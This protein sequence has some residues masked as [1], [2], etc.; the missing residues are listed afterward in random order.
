MLLPGFIFIHML[1]RPKTSYH[2]YLLVAFYLNCLPADLLQ[3]IPRST[4]HDWNHKDQIALYGYDWYNENRQLFDTLREVTASKQ[5]LRI[6]RALLRIIALKRFIVRYHDRIKGNI[7]HINEVV[8]NTIHKIIGT[9]SL[10]TTI[11]YL[12][13]SYSWYWQL[14]KNQR[15][16]SSVF[17]LCRIKY[18]A[19]LLVGEINIIKAYCSDPRLLLWP[20]ASVYHQIRRDKATF[21]TISTFY[22]YVSLLGLKRKLARHRR[23]NHDIGIRAHAPLQILH[24]DATV[25]RTADN[26]KS[27]I[28]LVQD[29]F[30]RAILGYTVAESCKAENTFENLDAVLQTYLIPSGISSCLLLTDDGPEN[31]GPVRNLIAGSVSPAINHL[32]AQRDIEF[33]NSMIEAANKQLKYRFLYHLPIANHPPLLKSLHH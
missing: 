14:K 18:P 16:R 25:F 1:V 11:K 26:R 15:C 13:R 12:Q 2:P 7:F 8:L 32:I 4:R 19:Q 33:S 22:K 10:K 3:R 29:N 17:S 21:F 23:K 24:A 9:I 30:S 27:Y 31:A 6:N 5:L 20:L 28:H